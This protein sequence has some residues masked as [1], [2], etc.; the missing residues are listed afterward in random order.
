MSEGETADERRLAAAAASVGRVGW[1][2]LI[3]GRSGR[4]WDGVPVMLSCPP[5]R[6]PRSGQ[7]CFP[8]VSC[9]SAGIIL[10]MHLLQVGKV[11]KKV[12]HLAHR[13]MANTY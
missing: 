3:A 13:K 5:S 12:R 4:V 2:V 6:S 10:S 7:P 9:R 1:H 11:Y 8:A